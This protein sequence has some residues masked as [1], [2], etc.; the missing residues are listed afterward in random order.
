MKALPFKVFR[1]PVDNSVS[2]RDEANPLLEGSIGNYL[3]D[4][5]SLSKI[6]GTNGQNEIIML[7]KSNLKSLRTKLQNSPDEILTA[8]KE[9][10]E[11][12]WEPE[13][14]PQYNKKG[15]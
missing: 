13:R 9:H 3:K 5:F 10:N 8:M 15:K 4:C 7:D 2:F 12:L 14:N 11:K 1:I 6:S